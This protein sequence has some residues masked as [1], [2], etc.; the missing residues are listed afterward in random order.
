ME[1]LQTLYKHTTTQ[2]LTTFKRLG[3]LW[4]KKLKQNI[5]IY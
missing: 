3:L 2:I 1:K 4:W 5:H